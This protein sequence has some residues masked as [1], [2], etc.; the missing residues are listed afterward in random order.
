MVSSCEREVTTE[1]FPENMS[2]LTLLIAGVAIISSKKHRN[3][4]LG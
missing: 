4:I 3:F 1:S 2:I